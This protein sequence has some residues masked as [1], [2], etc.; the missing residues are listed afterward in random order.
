MIYV[1]ESRIECGR[2]TIVND[3]SSGMS[4][5]FPRTTNQESHTIYE[6][7]IYSLALNIEKCVHGTTLGC[8]FYD[9]ENVTEIW[10][11]LRVVCGIRQGKIV[12]LAQSQNVQG[13][14][15]RGVFHRA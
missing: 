1:C 7:R 8:Y 11:V 14:K 3:K 4:S 5:E 12:P 10:R 2:F 15:G 9:N 13:A 6:S